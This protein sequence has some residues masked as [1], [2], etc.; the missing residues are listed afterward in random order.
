MLQRNY[1]NPEEKILITPRMK[2]ITDH[3]TEKKVADIG[4]DHA[5]IPIELIKTGKCTHVIAS[6][7]KEGPAKTALRHIQNNGLDIEVRVGA[8]LTVLKENEADQIIIAGMGGRMIESI[9]LNSPEIAK[10]TKLILQP[11]NAQYELR[12][13]LIKNGYTIACEDIAVE[14]FKV[15]NLFEIVPG[16]APLVYKN[17][18]DLHLPSFLSKHKYFQQLKNKKIR[19]FIKII[20]GNEKSAHRCEN[21]IEY[22]RDILN[23]ISDL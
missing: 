12:K 9:L 5:Y 14:G 11:M 16:A 18:Y 4:T 15:Y 13:F 6:D 8:G 19:E 10:T 17:D 1:V 20:N 3:V 23:K 21:V 2:L 22:Y 7:I